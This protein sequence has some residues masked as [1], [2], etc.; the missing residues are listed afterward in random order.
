M[1]RKVKIIILLIVVWSFVSTVV[2][3]GMN[4]TPELYQPYRPMMVAG[5]DQYVILTWG[6]SLFPGATVSTTAYLYT[7]I[8]KFENNTL[9][10]SNAANMTLYPTIDA[11][12]YAIFN[13]NQYIM[14][15]AVDNQGI[16]YPEGIFDLNGNILWE[17]S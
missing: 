13:T 4:L 7:Y 12:G 3:Y 17:A 15:V 14:Y 9:C 11:D 16:L 2:F 6:T 1:Q 5:Q 10:V 8:G